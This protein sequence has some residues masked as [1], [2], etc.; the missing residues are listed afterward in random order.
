MWARILTF[1][2]LDFLLHKVGMIILSAPAGS[3]TSPEFRGLKQAPFPISHECWRQPVISVDS[4]L[5]WAVG[6]RLG[7]SSCALCPLGLQHAGP[8]VFP[9]GEQADRRGSR[10]AD[11]RR[12]DAA[13]T[14][15]GRRFIGQAGRGWVREAGQIGVVHMFSCP[16]GDSKDTDT[17]GHFCPPGAGLRPPR[18]LLPLI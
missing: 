15:A 8:R 7:W 17:L 13:F 4:A 18:A 12:P 2:G 1:Q 9:H 3:Q 11:V 10:K 14:S 6:W 5:R 16:D